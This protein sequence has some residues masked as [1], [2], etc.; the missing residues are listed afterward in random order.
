MAAYRSSFEDPL[1][2]ANR[3]MQFDHGVRDLALARDFAG[4]VE[5][6]DAL[7][8]ARTIVS[9]IHDSMR[10]LPTAFGLGA[11]RTL[12]QIVERRGGNCVSYA[13][14]AVAVLRS[15][16]IPARLVVE[17]VCTNVSLLRAPAC[18]VRAPIGPTLNG[19]VWL[20][21]DVD[22]RW[23]PADAEL[24][25][26]GDDE[27]SAARLLRGVSIDAL[28]LRIKE[29]WKFPLR[30]RRLDASGQPDENVTELYLVE[31]LRA[32]PGL[33]GPLSAD[34]LEG[35]RYF[36]EAFDWTG[37]TGARILLQHRR[38]RRMSTAL[39]RLAAGVAPGASSSPGQ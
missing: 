12:E 15:H 20:E 39:A 2:V 18:L 33:K 7:R 37:R 24:G 10:V 28:G 3:G 17:E 34:W 9:R 16:G 29:R 38:L 27:W 14:L 36:A 5:S 23:L 6:D 19:H 35:V 22:G 1:H 26:F 31:K 4:R 32:L 13:V 11:P 21:A 8:T 30:I 25:I